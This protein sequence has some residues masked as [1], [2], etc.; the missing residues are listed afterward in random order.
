MKLPVGTIVVLDR[1]REDIGEVVDLANSIAA[2][3]LLAPIIVQP[4]GEG[5]YKLVAGGRRLA[6]CKSLG[7]TE[8]EA[9]LRDDLDEVSETEIELEENLCRTDLTDEEKAWA[10]LKIHRLKV[11]KYGKATN[12]GWTI[13]DT[14][15]SLK[16]S[17][18]T[19]SGF[20]SVASRLERIERGEEPPDE[21]LQTALKKSI[22][23]AVKVDNYRKEQAVLQVINSRLDE[24]QVEK[25]LQP[26]SEIL[27]EVDKMLWHGDC[28]ELI[29]RVPTETVHMIYTD[30]PYGIDIR[31]AHEKSGLTAD[32]YEDDS[33]ESLA[34]ILRSLCPEMYRV[35]KPDGFVVFWISFKNM[36]LLQ[37]EMLKAGFR[38]GPVPYFWVRPSGICNNVKLWPASCVD[39]ALIFAKGN[40][41]MVVQ[42]TRNW[43]DTPPL[44]PNDKDMALERPVE[45]NQEIIRRYTLGLPDELV[46]DPFAGSGSTLRAC[47]N[48]HVGGLAF[49]L[50]TTNYA[51]ARTKLFFH[52]AGRDQEAYQM[53]ELGYTEAQ[54]AKLNREAMAKIIADGIRAERVS[55]LPDGS[56][57]QFTA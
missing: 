31:K 51:A 38:V 56:I 40:P 23:E 37:S 15:K 30:S 57:K 43:L 22:W 11:A 13:E 7:H 18:C 17:Q 26:A 49:E 45:L 29:Q 14:G 32:L 35:L 8:I 25:S 4:F 5:T 12:G 48:L 16:M 53:L 10:I 2:H 21:A 9:T 39:I 44:N 34:A 1:Q 6:A 24:V 20:L 55:V 19:A 50:D 47:L 27:A 42:G 52:M 28:R 3:G 54:V 41:H 36:F 33:V 46:L